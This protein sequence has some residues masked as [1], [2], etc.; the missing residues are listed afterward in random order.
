M[1][2]AETIIAFDTMDERVELAKA[3]GADFGF[4]ALNCDPAFEIKQLTDKKGADV[5]IEISGSYA[6]LQ[7]AIRGVHVCGLIVG[8]SY[9][10]GTKT[11]ELGAEW[12][13]NRPTFISSMPV[14]GMPHRCYPMWDLSRL[15]QT[16]LK[17]LETGRLTTEPMVG[18]RFNYKVAVAAYQFIDEHP[19]ASL[20]TLFDYDEL[21]N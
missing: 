12:H 6:A 21:A 4:N 14:W 11:I 17:L 13:H 8:A 3:V 7:A 9:Y 18:K 10:S 2:G 20:K 15:E 16:A 5:I 1:N 19:E